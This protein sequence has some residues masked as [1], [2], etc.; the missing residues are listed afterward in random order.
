M[1][2]KGLLR[3]AVLSIALAGFAA[4]VP[5]RVHAQT[6]TAHSSTSLGIWGGM[7]APLGSD[8]T[9][10]SVGTSID[11]RNSFAGGARLTFWGNN[12]L[13]VEAVAGLTPAKVEVAGASVNETRSLN[14]FAAGLKLMI[15]LSPGMS[16]A[17]FHIGAGPAIIRRGHDVTN[18]NNSETN[19]GG[20]VGA[21]VRF[22]INQTL[23]VRFD[24]E[25]YIYNG[26]IENETK[27]RNDLITS[28]GLTIR[29]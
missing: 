18:E 4:L 19:L 26:T 2:T 28:A 23:G 21:G 3:I 8:P 22:P 27:T 17:G 1:S 24:V 9:A 16:P 25:D 15:G 11:R 6:T 10:T 5:G 12:V 7:F 20:V 13:G 14:I 29:F